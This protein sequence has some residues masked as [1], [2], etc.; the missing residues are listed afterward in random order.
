[1]VNA[2]AGRHDRRGDGRRDRLV[3]GAAP[4]DLRRPHAVGDRVPRRGRRRRSAGR[5]SPSATSA[6]AALG[7]LVLSAALGGGGRGGRSDESAAIGTVQAFALGLGFLFVG[8]YHGLLNGLD[9]LLFGTFLGITDGQ[10]RPCSG[11]RSR[12]WLLLALVATP[13]A[14]LR[15]GRRARWRGRGGV[16]VAACST[17]ASSSCSGWPSPR[18]PDHG[19][20]ARVRPARHAGRHRPGAHRRGPG[21]ASCLSVVDRARRHLA[22][23]RRSPTTPPTRSASGSRRSR[24]GLYVAVRWSR[25]VAHGVEWRRASRGAAADARP[26][27]HAQRVPRRHLHR[28]RLRARRLLRR[29]AHQVF[30]GDALSHVAFTGR[31]RRGRR[32][33]STSASACSPRRRRSALGMGASGDRAR[34]DDVVIGSVFAWVLGLG[35]LFLSIFTTR[36]ERDE[37][38]R[39]R[40]RAVRVDLRA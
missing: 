32:S 13:A 30:A 33:G 35:V 38:H 40:A 4:P 37:R 10:V 9:S 1:M 16:P 29:A 18:P 2:L 34:A 28:A 15:L 14:V 26:R 21:A 19:R 31:A 25:L 3:H 39:R 7:A 6:P 20:A 27:V 17:S 22:R 36:L 5:P 12:C 23:A 24:F 11:S 8:L